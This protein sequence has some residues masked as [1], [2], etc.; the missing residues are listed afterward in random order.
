MTL[1]REGDRAPEVRVYS[2]LLRVGAQVSLA[3]LVLT[4]LIYVGGFAGPRVPID[5]LP[6][7]WGLRASEY[8]RQ[9]DVPSGWGWVRLVR[10]GDILNYVGITMLSGLTIVGYLAILPVYVRKRDSA[11][12][13]IVL[14]EIAILLVAA[15]GWLVL[16]H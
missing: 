15:S 6:S 13:L 10:F 16:R 12:V 4:F 5:R 11:Y 1:P 7:Y 2:V 9:T 3:V 8:L 14:A